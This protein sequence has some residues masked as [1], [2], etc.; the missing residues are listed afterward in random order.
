VLSA[1][2]KLQQGLNPSL[3][4]F[5]EVHV[6]PND[7][8]WDAMTLGSG[9]RIDPLVLGIT[10]AGYD[11]E[12]LCGRLY[13]Y[14]Q[15]VATGEIV[16]ES[17]GIWWWEAPPDCDIYD[18]AG[19]NAAN[20]NLGE[21]LL[22]LEDIETSARQTSPAAFRRYRLNQ[23]TKS[24][25]S[26]LPPGAWDQCAGVVELDERLPAFVGV[27]MALKHDSIA[28]V[29][30]QGQDKGERIAAE[31]KVWFPDGIIDIAEVE[32]YLRF[33]HR[34]F[35]VV[36]FAYDPAYFERSAQALTDDGLPMVEFPQS[37]QRMVAAS[38]T[39]YHIITTGTLI[40]DGGPTFSDQVQS[41]AVRDTDVGWRL[42][43]GKSKRKIDAAI[44][45]IMALS[46]ATARQPPK[47][48]YEERGPMVIG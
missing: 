22:D 47:S 28:V 2:A 43:K 8:L 46:R 21:G 4:L 18:Q 20:P 30:V 33:L 41:A 37:A 25:E 48:V 45:L 10:T 27:D 44:A 31:A 42:S 15:R 3:V 24:Q 38:Q 39:A 34:R 26:W 23:W 32:N 9:A 7:E 35:N 29:I 6:Q 11:M 17:F 13:Q 12:S 40:H 1:E 5:D 36:E 16:D 14:G 19:W